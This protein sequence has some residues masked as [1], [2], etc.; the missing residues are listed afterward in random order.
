[1]ELWNKGRSGASEPVIETQMFSIKVPLVAEMVGNMDTDVVILDS[2]VRQLDS[3]TYE[4]APDDEFANRFVEKGLSK[5][6]YL[7][8]RKTG[9][10]LLLGFAFEDGD[11]F[12]IP[13]KESLVM[14]T[15]PIGK[16]DRF[17]WFA[18]RAK[19]SPK[20]VIAKNVRITLSEWNN[21]DYQSREE[22]VKEAKELLKEIREAFP[23]SV[24]P[25]ILPEE[26]E[27]ESKS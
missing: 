24:P 27:G 15:V 26:K 23:G 7:S 5:V 14:Q 22:D 17:A 3:V 11:K 25:S 10:K 20:K 19:N 12:Y 1:V 9:R 6:D 16:E 21:V 18:A 4:Y 2:I 8:G 13:S